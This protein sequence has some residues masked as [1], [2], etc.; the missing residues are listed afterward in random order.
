M[1]KYHK[2][3]PFRPG[4]P[5]N[6]MQLFWVG[7]ESNAFISVGTEIRLLLLLVSLATICNKGCSV[8]PTTT[9]YAVKVTAVISLQVQKQNGMKNLAV[10]CRLFFGTTAGD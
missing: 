1:Q 2:I 8:G 7:H 6:L 3:G 9:P 4:L 5:Y 10:L